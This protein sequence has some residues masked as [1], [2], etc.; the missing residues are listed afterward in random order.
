MRQTIVA[1]LAIL[2]IALLVYTSIGGSSS[3]PS[4]TGYAV[5]SASQG[6]LVLLSGLIE[7]ES[8]ISIRGDE[9]LY[10]GGSTSLFTVDFVETTSSNGVFRVQ[11]TQ[12]P[13]AFTQ[14]AGAALVTK[15]GV[16]G[17][18][19]ATLTPQEL[20]EL[21]RTQGPGWYTFTIEPSDGGFFATSLFLS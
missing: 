4:L 13:R 17:G 3:S 19:Y 21:R 2:G 5:A 15:R 18:L 9:L 11:K 8:A 10:A 6:R 7:P 14:G 1:L 16:Q 20:S 12:D